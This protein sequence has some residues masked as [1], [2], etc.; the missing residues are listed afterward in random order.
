M[1]AEH[2]NRHLFELTRNL[3]IEMNDPK[4]FWRD[5]FLIACYL[6]NHT[7]ST[8]LDGLNGHIS[9]SVLYS[10]DDTSSLSPR[11]FDYICFVNNHSTNQTKLDPKTLEYVLLI[12][13][14]PI[15]PNWILKRWNV[16]WEYSRSQKR[17]RSYSTTL[18]VFVISIYVTIFESI[19]YFSKELY[20]L[21]RV[22]SH[23]QKTISC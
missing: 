20:K 9:Y 18:H 23:N 2:K 7:P 19:S 15:E 8:T 16:Y 13:I 17:Y 12:I 1:V 22:H 21:T 5:A 14:V 10:K 6:T 4:Y 11:I 3:L